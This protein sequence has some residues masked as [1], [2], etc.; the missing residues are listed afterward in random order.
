MRYTHGF[1]CTHTRSLGVTLN[2]N[3]PYLYTLPYSRLPLFFILPPPYSVHRTPSTILP[4]PS[5]LHNTPP[6]Y[7]SPQHATPTTNAQLV[8]PRLTTRQP[9]DD[10]PTRFKPRKPKPRRITKLESTPPPT[11]NET[12]V[13]H[14]AVEPPHHPSSLPFH[15]T[16]HPRLSF[17]PKSPLTYSPSRSRTNTLNPHTHPS[18]HQ[19]QTLNTNPQYIPQTHKSSPQTHTHLQDFQKSQ[20]LFSKF[21]CTG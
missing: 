15:S 21:G 4:L 3:T 5:S 17:S 19:A 13:R 9:T 20:N 10:Y 18:T 16:P 2:D 12:S 11:C 14:L 6:Q 1:S 7:P 8:P